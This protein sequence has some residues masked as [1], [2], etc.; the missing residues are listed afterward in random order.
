MQQEYLAAQTNV[1]EISIY[2]HSIPGMF[3]WVDMHYTISIHIYSCVETIITWSAMNIRE[4]FTHKR[5]RT[6]NTYFVVLQSWP[7]TTIHAPNQAITYSCLYQVSNNYRQCIN[8]IS[9]Y[10]SRTIDCNKTCRRF[11]WKNI[12]YRSLLVRQVFARKCFMNGIVN[13]AVTRRY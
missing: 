5:T 4:T 7:Q 2:P 13:K 10:K 12:Q 9:S 11:N 1:T 6:Q 8:L 3:P